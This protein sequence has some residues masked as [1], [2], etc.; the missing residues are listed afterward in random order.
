[1][2]LLA[3]TY[4]LIGLAAAAA[5]ILV[6]LVIVLAVRRRRKASSP[7]LEGLTLE[8]APEEQSDDLASIL[9]RPA[10][11]ESEFGFEIREEA[12]SAI[13]PAAKPA[14][15]PVGRPA[16]KPA[17]KYEA[18]S[19]LPGLRPSPA[20]LAVREIAA[21]HGPLSQ[22][23]QRRLGLYRRERILQAVE[24]VRREVMKA[25][26]PDVH[27]LARLDAIAAYVHELA[28]KEER[29]PGPVLE[30]AVSTE[31]LLPAETPET[32]APPAEAAIP[33]APLEKQGSEVAVAEETPLVVL[34]ESPEVPVYAEP[35]APQEVP[36][37]RVIEEVAAEPVP[38][39]V[40]AEP[41]CEVVEEEVV[42]VPL[43]ASGPPSQ[44]L[45]GLSAAEL[46]RLLAPDNDRAVRLAAVDRLEELGGP[47]A[48]KLLDSC[49]QDSDVEVQ[50]KALQAAERLLARKKKEGW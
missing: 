22:D 40:V 10:P 2:D 36:A 19:T 26:S 32:A 42:E 48:L 37:E 8:A 16:V 47:E 17:S 11:G 4:V 13:K 24:E 33:E 20:L 30:A 21:R 14:A 43:E 15:T 35:E 6:A 1:M 49:L 46:G 38:E 27:A 39:E 7:A 18:A 12:G 5:C 45:A 9:A 3:N 29:E 23:E 44:D 28:Q 50:L 25:R 34:E 41:V 31:A